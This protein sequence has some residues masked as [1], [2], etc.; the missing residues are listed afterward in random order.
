MNGGR[1]AG[2]KKPAFGAGKY[3]VELAPDCALTRRIPA[4]FNIGRI[5]EQRQH[6]LFAVFCK[7]VKIKQP[8]VSGRGIDLEITG[9]YHNPERRMDSQR[10]AIH[11]AVCHL[12]RMN[13][14]RSNLDALS[15]PYFPKICVVE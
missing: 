15:R 4:A 11:K 9:V 12:D 10:N 14:E 3:L 6:T 8:I 13:G 5:L 2:D 1:E 7:C